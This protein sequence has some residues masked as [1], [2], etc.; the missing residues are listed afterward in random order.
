MRVSTLLKTVLW[1]QVLLSCS[2]PNTAVSQ[3]QP[4]KQAIATKGSDRM[5]LIDAT[6]MTIKSRF[7]LPGGFERPAY[8]EREFGTFLENLPLYP[9][10]R[11][12]HYFNGKIKARNDIYNSVVKL[13]IGT[14]DLH[15]CADAVMRLRADYLYRQKRYRDIKFNFLSDGKPRAYASYVKGDYSYTKYWKYMEYVFTY[16]NTASLHDQLPTVKSTE[17]VKIGDTF[18][19]K[20]SPIGHAV[21]VVDLAKNKAGKTIVLLAQ[22]YMPAQEIQ[23]LNNW[24]DP[25]LSPWYD[26]DHDIIR[27]PEWTFYPKNLKTWE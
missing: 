3:A 14:R 9:A 18:I 6:G 27:T 2:Q 15:Q 13:D 24:N 10:E 1:F 8:T 21:M 11:E 19:Q 26:I 7:L 25:A 22:S 17:A 16:A 20:G 23:I 4:E 5:P 12:V